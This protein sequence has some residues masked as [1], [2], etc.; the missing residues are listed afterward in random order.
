MPKMFTTHFR[1]LYSQC[2]YNKAF[3][4]SI[5]K[6]AAKMNKRNWKEKL[7]EVI[8][9]IATEKAVKTV[10][11]STPIAVYEVEVPAELKIKKLDEEA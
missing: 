1:V 5:E 4:K 9:N 7:A 10:G 2:N 3:F 8:V 11:K 6:R